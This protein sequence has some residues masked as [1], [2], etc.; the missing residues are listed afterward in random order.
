MEERQVTVDGTT[1]ALQRPFIVHRDPEPHRDGGH[2]PAARGPARPLHGAD[3]DG[4]PVG[5]QP[6]ST[7]STS[8][9]ARVAARRP[10]PGDR[11]R[12]PS[13]RIDRRRCARCTPRPA[14][15]QYVVDLVTRPRA[16]LGPAPRRVTSGRPAPAARQPR[17]TPRSPAATTSCP[18][19]CRSLASP[20]LAHRLMPTGETQLARRTTADV[21]TDLLPGAGA[22]PHPL[23]RGAMR[24]LRNVLTTRGGPSSASGH[25]AR[26]RRVHLG[27]HD[28]TR[29][30]VLLSRCRSCQ[31]ARAHSARPGCASP[32]STAAR[33]HRVPASRADDALLREPLDVN[34][35][36]LPRRGA[37][38]LRPWA[39]G[40][41][42]SSAAPARAHRP[43]DYAV[44]SHL[45]GRHRLGPLG[46]R[47]R[48]RSACRPQRLLESHDRAPRAAADH[49]PVRRAS[50]RSAGWAPRAISAHLIALHGEDDQ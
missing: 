32:A 18:T 8:H 30:G 24:A 36:D 2:L 23:R 12:R 47:S 29:F 38:R 28:L 31:G 37:P 48:T 41:A 49:R 17:A 15:K 46:V 43:I 19:T 20:V 27:T 9:S 45:R 14:V 13:I 42:S 5:A 50:P 16:R 40:P 26:P 35:A 1:Y 25:R 6:S 7:C 33:A 10:A 44:R 3:L 22:G 4:L 11:R 34:D 21:V 39:T